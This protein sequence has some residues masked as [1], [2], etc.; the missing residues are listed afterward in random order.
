M[1]RTD[2]SENHRSAMLHINFKILAMLAIIGES[3]IAACISDGAL[4]SA[5]RE[6][7]AG[8]DGELMEN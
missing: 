1:A 5:L 4:T 2:E 3:A 8:Y 7:M 6:D